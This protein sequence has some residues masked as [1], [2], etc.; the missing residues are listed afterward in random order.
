MKP[1]LTP[2]WPPSTLAFQLTLLSSPL[3]IPL[4]TDSLSLSLSLFL[5]LS[6]SLSLSHTHTHTHTHGHTLTRLFQLFKTCIHP[7]LSSNVSVFFI[8]LY[9][10]PYFQSCSC[11]FRAA[12]TSR[13]ITRSI[14][15]QNSYFT[16]PQF[17]TIYLHLLMIS[18]HSYRSLIYNTWHQFWSSQTSNKL[19]PLKKLQSPGLLQTEPHDTNKSFSPASESIT[20][21]LPAPTSIV[22]SYH[23]IHVFTT[24]K[25]IRIAV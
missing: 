5:S 14:L 15:P 1:P 13:I 20:L 24:I 12:L 22:A 16:P 11:G 17:R 18:K 23:L 2:N 6:F 25:I 4:L 7:T 19:R 9:H 3:E 10:P 21:A 8:T